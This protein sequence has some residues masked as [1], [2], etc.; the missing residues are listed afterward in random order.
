[1]PVREWFEGLSRRE[2]LLV[3]GAAALVVV[4]VVVVGAVRPL[5]VSR[6]RLSGQLT[7]KQAVLDDIERVA[8]RVGQVSGSAAPQTSTGS[9]SLVVLIDR[10]T[11]SRGL[12]TY[13]KRNEPDGTASIRLRFENVPFD[14]LVGWLVEIQSS[15][16]IGVASANADPAAGA[17]RVNANLQLTRA[18]PD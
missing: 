12:G 18:A 1:M 17:G 9:E 6:Q 2:K 10:T 15:S 11:R 5:T 13:L 7:E 16:G 4:A 8:A 3:S 14:D